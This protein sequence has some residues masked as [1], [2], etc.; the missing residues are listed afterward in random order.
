MQAFLFRHGDEHKLVLWDAGTGSR[1]LK[2]TG[3]FE[4]R[5]AVDA[6]GA[7]VPIEREASGAQHVVIGP[8]PIYVRGAPAAAASA[9]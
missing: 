6:L 9:R 3:L 7:P 8:S 2:L 1:R 4:G 5:E